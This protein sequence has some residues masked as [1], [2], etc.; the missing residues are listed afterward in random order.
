M[1]AWFVAKWQEIGN[2]LRIH[3]PKKTLVTRQ[4]GRIRKGG[5]TLIWLSAICVHISTIEP[6]GTAVALL[7]TARAHKIEPVWNDPS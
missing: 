6:S 1:D 4:I 5:I 3:V 2:P 7:P